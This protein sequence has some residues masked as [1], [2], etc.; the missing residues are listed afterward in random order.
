M[1]YLAKD[2]ARA[3]DSKVPYTN[4]REYWQWRNGT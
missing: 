4:L 2:M 3:I 1:N